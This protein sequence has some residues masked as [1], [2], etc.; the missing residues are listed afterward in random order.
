MVKKEELY[1]AVTLVV[2]VLFFDLL[3]HR[4]PGHALHRLENL[5]LNIL[6]LLVVIVGGETWKTLLLSALNL[7]H[8]GKLA[9][10]ASLERIPGVAKIVVGLILA[11][12]SLY[13]V[14]CDRMFGSYVD[15]QSVGKDFPLGF[16]STKKRL[17]RMI[18]GF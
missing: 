8:P 17:A 6:A 1:Q 3:E 18:I 4:R 16:V 2:I 11:D 15:P 9:S 12:L 14:H 13:W 5:P 10:L 7:L